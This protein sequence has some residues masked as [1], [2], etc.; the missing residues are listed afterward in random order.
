[1]S[2]L[3]AW[4][5]VVNWVSPAAGNRRL[6]ARIKQDAV[7]K[8]LDGGRRRYNGGFESAEHSRDAASWLTSRL[9]P[10]SALEEARE[11]Q[12][13]RADSAYK[14]HE[15]GASHVEGRANRV[16]G[17]GTSLDPSIDPDDDEF[18][19]FTEEK[20]E[21]WNA[22][23]RR[24]WARQALRIG[25]GNKPLW[26]VQ[27]LLTKH[28]ER[29]GEW[30][31]LI[32][33]KFDAWSPTTLKV[34]AIHPKRVETPPGKEG[35]KTVRMGVQLNANGEAVGYYVRDSQPG[36][37]LDT[38]ENHRYIPAYYKNGLPRM[39]HYFDPSEAG[40]HRG[41][42]RMQVG[43]KR[44]KNSDEYEDAEIERNYIGACLSA[45]VRTDLGL[46]DATAGDVQD[47][48]G[49]RVRSFSPGMIQYVG[50]SDSVDIASPQGAPASYESFMQRQA[51]SFA[52]GAGTSYPFLTN[53]FRGLNYNTLKVVWNTE[54]A[55]C[56]VS[57]QAQ[58]DAI[59][60]VYAHFVNRAILV[61]GI[62]D[63]GVGEYRSRPWI[64][65]AV[66]VIPPARRSIDPAREDNA[67][68]RLIENQVKPASDMVE[69]KN[70]QPAPQVYKRI[71]RD[72]KQREDLGLVAIERV[73]T[74]Q[75]MPGDLNDESSE[76][77]S[78]RQ[79]VGSDA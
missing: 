44:L 8:A 18:G 68:I 52:A 39:I 58:A 75:T 1:M 64:Y 50:E 56:D 59:C 46:E 32:G 53:D 21:G 20:A 63:V 49:K 12:L 40:E 31:L 10:D 17:T 24:D 11:T 48:N 9:S 62:I 65:S 51:M 26:E 29:K 5:R 27:R 38:N 72:K 54:E 74:Q 77:N 4:D 19:G 7:L 16:T 23:L 42:P 15:L 28:L 36:D 25:K 61:A 79:E 43:L 73:D 66:R 6:A 2:K 3:N 47:A 22:R 67:D 57:H 33:D 14:N 55:A 45:F 69:R 76:A 35:D 71:A 34:E 30:F 60:W 37:T 13:E 41:F 78:E 70:G